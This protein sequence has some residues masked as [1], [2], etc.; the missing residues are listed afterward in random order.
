MAVGLLWKQQDRELAVLS[1]K[2]DAVEAQFAQ[3]AQLAQLKV[4]Q[5]HPQT[6]S[7]T[8]STSSAFDPNQVCQLLGGQLTNQS[9]TQHC[10][11]SSI[12]QLQSD[13]RALHTEIRTKASSMPA[14]PNVKHILPPGSV[15]GGAE[16]TE[17]D[18][19]TLCSKLWGKATCAE[20]E[21]TCPI[22][23]K[24]VFF[25]PGESRRGRPKTHFICR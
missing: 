12:I 10:E 20:G 18:G 5:P 19:K 11:L 15:G 3:L 24:K 8:E 25:K 22:G 7:A 14:T 2:L 9:T 13:L 16:T 17:L 6:T 21:V 23:T 1:K 4:P